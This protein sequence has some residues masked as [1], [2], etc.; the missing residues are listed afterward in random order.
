M[1]LLTTNAKLEKSVIGY[2]LL[3]LALAPL[4]IGNT[5]NVCKWAGECAKTCIWTSGM[6]AFTRSKN[7]KIFRKQFFF[8]DRQ[9]FLAQLDAEIVLEKLAARQESLQLAIR[10]NTYSDILW[11]SIAPEIFRRHNDVI[12]Y[13]YTK[14]PNPALRKVPKNYKL[15]YSFSEKTSEK[16]FSAW[17]KKASIAVVFS[18]NLP[19]TF[20]GYP[21]FDGDI[22]DARFL[23]KPKTIIGLR[24]KNGLKNKESRFKQ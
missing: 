24:A 1:K 16:D 18:G 3:G 7:A 4:K 20:K 6:N 23:D 12:F 17:I 22:S 8:D 9:A 2:R 10:L 11:E 15:T 21:V 14:A 5:P 13:D 19:A